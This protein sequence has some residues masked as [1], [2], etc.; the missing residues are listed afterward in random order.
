ML[1]A[2]V[3]A[4]DG[5]SGLASLQTQSENKTRFHKK[6]GFVFIAAA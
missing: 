3:L 5:A 2:R 1:A 6:P 4:V